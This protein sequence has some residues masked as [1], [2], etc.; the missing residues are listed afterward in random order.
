MRNKE[1]SAEYIE[2]ICLNT[3]IIIVR[4]WVIRDSNPRTSSEPQHIHQLA[5]P[6]L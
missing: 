5:I 3:K 2:K 1:S 6:N 4:L